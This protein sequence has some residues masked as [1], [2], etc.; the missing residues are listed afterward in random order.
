MYST[1]GLYVHKY[2]TLRAESTI[3]FFTLKT[4]FTHANEWDIFWDFCGASY[5]ESGEL[6]SASSAQQTE[7]DQQRT[8]AHPVN[9]LSKL[10]T[11][12]NSLCVA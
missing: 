6:L 10:R 4:C 5:R 1:F 8:E 11:V 7:E 2:F 12:Q 3:T 9:K